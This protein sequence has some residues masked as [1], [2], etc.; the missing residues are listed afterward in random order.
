MKKKTFVCNFVAR[1]KPYI[2]ALLKFQPRAAA[3]KWIN[4]NDFANAKLE[5]SGREHQVCRDQVRLIVRPNLKKSFGH[6][7]DQTALN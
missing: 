4:R 3:A 7:S 6:E 2:K 1:E 5:A